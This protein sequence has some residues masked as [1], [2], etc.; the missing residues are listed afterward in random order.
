MYELKIY[1]P[2]GSKFKKVLGENS[3]I[4]RTLSKTILW[5]KYDHI[6]IDTNVS[7][8]FSK[9]EVSKSRMLQE[10][11]KDANR[12]YINMNID[13]I[14]DYEDFIWENSNDAVYIIKNKL[15]SMDMLR[16]LQLYLIDKLNRGEFTCTKDDTGV[17]IVT[18]IGVSYNMIK[19]LMPFTE[20]HDYYITLIN[21]QRVINNRNDVSKLF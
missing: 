14:F 17:F 7:I 19:L 12:L 6:V 18:D 15:S 4:V 10:L 1:T 8:K 21:I 9:E 5:K 2:K 16:R 11:F 20:L 3:K 13:E